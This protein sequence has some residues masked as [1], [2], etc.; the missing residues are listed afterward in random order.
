MNLKQLQREGAMAGDDENVAME[1]DALPNPASDNGTGVAE[2]K[3]NGS[4][5]EYNVNA[6]N[7]G[8]KIHL[9]PGAWTFAWN[10]VQYLILNTFLDD[11][12]L[13]QYAARYSGYT[14]IMR[15]LF[16][17]SKSP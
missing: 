2:S 13:E 11:T 3:T 1:V 5:N 10:I 12:D 16:I 7:F 9:H 8:T 14:K 6:P 4:G 15:L 17:A